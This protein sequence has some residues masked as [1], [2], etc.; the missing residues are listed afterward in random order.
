MC[1]LTSITLF[2]YSLFYFVP[3]KLMLVILVSHV[4]Q[5]PISISIE[6]YTKQTTDIL[7]H[8]ACNL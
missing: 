4:C 7:K 1:A 8:H 2:T 5:L 3:V 6:K